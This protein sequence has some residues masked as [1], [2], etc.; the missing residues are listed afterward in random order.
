M[1]VLNTFYHSQ[2][3]FRTSNNLTQLKKYNTL[4]GMLSHMKIVKLSYFL[5]QIADV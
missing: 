1:R 5:G 3:K 4:E 2:I